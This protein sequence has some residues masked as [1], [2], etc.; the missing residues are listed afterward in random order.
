MRFNGLALGKAAGLALALLF[1]FSSA[2]IPHLDTFGDREG[3]SDDDPGLV[4]LATAMWQKFV[5]DE[6]EGYPYTV[7]VDEHVHWV[8]AA[9]M[10]ETGS[11]FVSFPSGE[12]VE[13]EGF[14][15]LR[16]AVH[17]IGHQLV[18]AEIQE[19][20]G[21]S[22]Q[23]IH[24]YGPALWWT[25]VAF[26]VY[27]MLRPHPAAIPAAAFVGLVPSSPR[28]L[29]PAMLVPIA[30]S[31]AWLP[32]VQIMSEEGRRRVTSAALLF[33]LVLWAFFV[34]LIGGF[35]AVG[36]VLVGGVVGSA[37]Q[38]DRSLALVGLG[39]IPLV[40]LY[41]SFESGVQ[42]EI[43]RIGDLPVDFTV[44]D[45]FGLWALGLWALG[46]LLLALLPVR[47]RR[48]E[49]STWAGVSAVA[50]G[51]IV[52]SVVALAP[53]LGYRPY[54]TYDRWHPVFFLTAS[55]PAGFAVARGAALFRDTVE[56]MLPAFRARRSMAVGFGLAVGMVLAGGA[57]SAGVG[58]QVDQP[59][60]KVLDDGD[61]D[62]ISWVEQNGLGDE[63]DVF[64]MHPWKAP[65]LSAMTGMT[66]HAYL[67]PGSPPVNGEDYD[68]FARTGGAMEL[69]ILNDITLVVAEE[70]P[71]FEEFATQREGVHTMDEQITREILEIRRSQEA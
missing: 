41:R 46:M 11:V 48:H 20:T 15:S 3:L 28:F 59:Y 66:P 18:L 35:A 55:V 39:L 68:S 60:Y 70:K 30:T 42:R 50:L 10:Q 44:F 62:R 33:L 56:G 47:E 65:V 57:A 43:D 45:G 27:A 64:L 31:L 23:T 8:Q 29:G 61:W 63:N 21:I 52:V 9:A 4:N 49:L 38:R 14:F 69:F 32:A 26:G 24:E 71:P 6:R 22:W 54:A 12:A 58:A 25:F 51:F 2:F 13:Q 34:H 36:V 5:T 53:W 16:G 1:V 40:W 67:Q 37:Q 17:H 7:H 19:L